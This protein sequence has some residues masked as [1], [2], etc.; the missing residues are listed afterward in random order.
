M[1]M[2]FSYCLT[3]TITMVFTSFFLW[4]LKDPHG[5]GST[6]HCFY[7]EGGA[8]HLPFISKEGE[9]NDPLAVDVTGRF[10][11]GLKIAAATSGFNTINFALLLLATCFKK[12]GCI[13]TLTRFANF[14]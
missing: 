8:D 3:M 4:A 13:E 2:G 14:A 12:W 9:L 11:I 1:S 6:L 7:K 5:N 10:L